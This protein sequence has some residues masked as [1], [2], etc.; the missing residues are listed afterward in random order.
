MPLLLT[1]QHCQSQCCC[2][3]KT[4]LTKGS[5]DCND[6][7]FV[8]MCGHRAFSVAGPNSLPEDMPDLECSVDSYRQSLK[9]FLFFQ[10]IQGTAS[11]RAAYDSTTFTMAASS[12]IYTIIH[13]IHVAHYRYWC[14]VF[15]CV[16]VCRPGDR[17]ARQVGCLPRPALPRIVRISPRQLRQS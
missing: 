13:N 5:E 11:R 4:V 12:G 3:L 8:D 1:D 14:A 16:S 2:Y 17:P 9:T 6:G 7:L 15:V 10:C